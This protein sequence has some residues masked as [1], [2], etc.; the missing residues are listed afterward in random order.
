MFNQNTHKFV[1]MDSVT[2]NDPDCESVG[3]DLTTDKGIKF[4]LLCPYIPPERQDQIEKLCSV[5]A[6]KK[7]EKPIIIAGDL[8]AKSQEWNN[9]KANKSG[10]LIEQMLTKQN[11]ICL[12]DGQPT[13]RN[14]TSVI[15][16]VL[17]SAQF[18]KCITSCDTL[19]HDTIKSDHISILTVLDVCSEDTPSTDSMFWQLNRVIGQNG[20]PRWK[21]GLA[22]G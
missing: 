16:L 15:D 3:I 12:N 11:M 5:I 9:I 10:E 1:A 14:S 21:K 20:R 2:F 18:Q 13:R 22:N 6:E 4:T 7:S 8:N 17:T 19:T